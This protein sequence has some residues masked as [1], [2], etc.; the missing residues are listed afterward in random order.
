MDFKQTVV[1]N[2][3]FIRWFT[4][5]AWICIDHHLPLKSET[6]ASSTVSTASWLTAENTQ[7]AIIKKKKTSAQNQKQ[8]IS[9]IRAFNI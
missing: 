5:A 2:Y 4:L 7:I 1:R 9:H 3:G 6:P 8:Y